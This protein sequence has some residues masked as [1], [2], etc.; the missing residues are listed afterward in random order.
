[1]DTP[2][3]IAP[4][5]L[6]DRMPLADRVLDLSASQPSFTEAEFGMVG[7]DETLDLHETGRLVERT[8]CLREL[9]SGQTKQATLRERRDS[10]PRPPA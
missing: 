9:P 6:A 3:R 7:P 5:G 8:G 2:V 1:M 4:I 10:N